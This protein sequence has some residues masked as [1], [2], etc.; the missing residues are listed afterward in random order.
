MKILNVLKDKFNL[1]A[2]SNDQVINNANIEINQ[3]HLYFSRTDHYFLFLD[4]FDLYKDLYL[5]FESNIEVSL[6]LLS[7][8]SRKINVNFHFDLKDRTNLSIYTGLVSRRKT[9][10]S[11]K[12]DFNLDGLSSLEILNSIT[13]NG[14]LELEDTIH[15]NSEEAKV[16]LDVLNV[17]GSDS[18]YKISQNVNHN[19]KTTFSSINNWIIAEDKAK[20]NYS[21][22]GSIAKG[23]EFSN[24]MQNNK[25][26]MLSDDS[27]I[28]VEPKLYIDEYN[29]SA[30][31]GA[32]IGQIDELQLYYLLSRGLSENEARSL[33]IS[34]YTNPF[35]D[36]IK[37]EDIQKLLVKTIAKL[38]RRRLLNE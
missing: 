6:F 11:I 2:L 5:E 9:K 16:D 3:N 7:Y 24:C 33:I 22:T 38:I 12:R 21:V 19:A 20:M 29:V 35:I 30:S 34:G 23:N 32:A 8:N 14:Y 17:G 28:I 31:H 25:G 10:L 37:D 18:V 26:I 1:I 13:Y 36:K 4:N 27:E 15:L